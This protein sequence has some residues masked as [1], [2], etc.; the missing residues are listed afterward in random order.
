MLKQKNQPHH[1]SFS[2]QSTLKA[3]LNLFAAFLFLF[4][5]NSFLSTP[6]FATSGPL[7][8]I[9]DN[10]RLSVGAFPLVVATI[11]YLFAIYLVI[12]AIWR[13]KSNVENPNSASLPSVVARFVG[14]GLLFAAPLFLDS[15]RL[16]IGETPNG[17]GAPPPVPDGSIGVGGVIDNLTGSLNSPE[18]FF[19]I[20]SYLF[21]IG[22]AVWA[23]AE[24]IRHADSP[25]QN[26]MRRPIMIAFAAG[27]LM[28]FPVIMFALKNSLTPGVARFLF[29]ND[30]A[31]GGG[32]DP[33][34]LDQILI[35]FVT[36]LHG[37]L[38]TLLGHFATIAGIAFGLVGIFR[39][40]RGA[41][42]GAKGPVGGG[43]IGTFI[44][45]AALTS[46]DTMM[47]ATQTSLF[48]AGANTVS[49]Y[50]EI[51]YSNTVDADFAERSNQAF[52]AVLIFTQIVGFFS[53]VRGI[54]ILRSY[55]EGDGQASM[56]SGFT[57]IIAGA[58]A[59]NMTAFMS[60]V[61]ETL[62]LVGLTFS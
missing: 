16:L 14:A 29:A 47:G 7:D 11:A 45:A 24:F 1:Y 9:V 48:G 12:S 32:A 57:H 26:P 33:L 20:I 18:T 13:L 8:T 62:G 56:A 37:P 41:Q 3:R 40:I 55:S 38:L 23:V 10:V 22:L 61:Q 43:T 34:A 42:D 15:L 5:I 59:V 54:F 36:N 58:I 17:S 27:A 60:A 35:R 25:G 50:A 19:A 44:A 4:L 21:G 39:L 6:A 53:F 31:I 30:P 49:T 51:A 28:A 2:S 52:Q 46:V